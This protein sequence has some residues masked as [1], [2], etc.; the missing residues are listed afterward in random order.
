MR[1]KEDTYSEPGVMNNLTSQ[2]VY[3]PVGQSSVI[4]E[5]ILHQAFILPLCIAWRNFFRLIFVIEENIIVCLHIYL[6]FTMT[7]L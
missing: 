3:L 2:L 5:D 1:R 4:H 6:I 7:L